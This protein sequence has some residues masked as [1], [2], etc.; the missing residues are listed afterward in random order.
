[1]ATRPRRHSVVTLRLTVTSDD[2]F[3]DHNSPTLTPRTRVLPRGRN[4][5][6]R[7]PTSPLPRTPTSPQPRSPSSPHRR[8][9]G[10]PLLNRA[11]PSPLSPRESSSRFRYDN[12]TEERDASHAGSSTSGLM[13]RSSLLTVP[14]MGHDPPPDQFLRAPRQRSSSLAGPLHSPDLIRYLNGARER[15]AAPL[16]HESFSLGSSENEGTDDP[17]PAPRA[18]QTS[19]PGLVIA[20][21][22]HITTLDISTTVRRPPNTRQGAIR[23]ADLCTAAP[24]PS[25]IGPHPPLPTTLIS[26]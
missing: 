16:G 14:L 6:A 26:P 19:S 20:V 10:S 24:S 23:D 2:V 12:V 25:L 22:P 17:S 15:A 7:T 18:K 3:G 13:R 5:F 21:V 8:C 11:S 1:M 4:Y 9:P